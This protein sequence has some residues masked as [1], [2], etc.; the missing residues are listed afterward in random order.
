VIDSYEVAYERRLAELGM[1]QAA[2]ALTELP[3]LKVTVPAVTTVSLAELSLPVKAQAA[4]GATLRRI[5]I[6]VNGVAEPLVRVPG[7]RSFETSVSL[8][9]SNGRNNVEVT[10]IDSL[11]RRS[12]TE[13]FAIDNTE[14]A[15]R[16][17]YVAAVGVSAYEDTNQSLRFA[18]KD[19]VDL[20]NYFRDHETTGGNSE[21]DKV[22]VLDPLTDA[23]ATSGNIRSLSAK[24]SAAGVNDTVVLFFAG[25]GLVDSKLDFYFA[26]W[27][28]N[29]AQPAE[30]GISIEE[31]EKILGASH[32]RR[33]LLLV[34]ACHSGELD[35]S[36]VIRVTPKSAPEKTSG[37]R[38]LT[39][40]TDAQSV[41][42]FELERSLFA[43]LREN[44]GTQIISAS[45]GEEVA[46]EYGE[47]S[48]GIFTHAVLEGLQN[49]SADEN[50]DGHVSVSE[51]LDFV[52]AKV[53]EI[54]QGRQTPTQRQANLEDDF[55][56]Q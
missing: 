49:S 54:T 42:A 52:A 35:K 32:S 4:A 5:E 24:L 33:R 1:R 40:G 36:G 20:A 22:V 30:H 6:Q 44:T 8:E 12:L 34:D 26:P 31:M 46:F 13:E 2:P 18:A 55:V 11:E 50:G 7:Q 38:G 14:R 15:A 9:L 45:R 16:T 39:I 41:N 25:H 29:F 47:L 21:F 17:L 19:A 28:M 27:D 51:L 48:N 10:A 37:N 3:Q 56:I 53:K 23:A 43:D